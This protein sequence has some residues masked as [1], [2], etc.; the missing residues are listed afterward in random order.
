MASQFDK[1]GRTLRRFR[2]ERLGN[3][4]PFQAIDYSIKALWWP[5]PGLL[6]PYS[7]TKSTGLTLLWKGSYA[8]ALGIGPS[9][10]NDTAAASLKQERRVVR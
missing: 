10:W 7:E 1:R 5:N 4:P 2:G 8:H 6:V 3:L 9:N